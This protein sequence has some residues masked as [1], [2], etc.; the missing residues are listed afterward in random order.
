MIELV[1]V[2]TILQA[3]TRL[4]RCGSIIISIAYI[5]LFLESLGGP[6]GA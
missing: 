1:I 2:D 3:M 5:S 6:Q 4:R